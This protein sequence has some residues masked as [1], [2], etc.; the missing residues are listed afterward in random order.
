MDCK[1]DFQDKNER[2]LT[3]IVSIHYSEFAILAFWLVS[4]YLGV[5]SGLEAFWRTSN[6]DGGHNPEVLM[7]LDA[8]FIA[9]ESH[10]DTIF[11]Q[12]F[13]TYCNKIK[14]ENYKGFKNLKTLSLKVSWKALTLGTKNQ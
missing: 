13:L 14:T 1:K 11:F 7:I 3:Y 8:V 2:H 10:P 6:R 12:H 9:T 4:L 5:W